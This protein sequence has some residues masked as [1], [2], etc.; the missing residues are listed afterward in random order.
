MLTPADI[1]KAWKMRAAGAT[2]RDISAAL[3]W[4]SRAIRLALF[5]DKH[6]RPDYR[7]PLPGQ[8]KVIKRNSTVPESV[9]AE[10]ERMYKIRYTEPLTL[11]Q[12]YLGDPLPGQS[13]LDRKQREQW[14]NHEKAIDKRRNPSPGNGLE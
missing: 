8:H 6:T 12:Q 2:F 3:G 1:L 4:S 13:A 7:K 5:P 14:G 10:R 9:L 11:S